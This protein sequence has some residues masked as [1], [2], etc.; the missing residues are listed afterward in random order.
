MPDRTVLVKGPMHKGPQQCKVVS[1]HVRGIPDPQGQVLHLLPG[2]PNL[3]G[4]VVQ[5]VPGNPTWST[6]HLWSC[7]SHQTN[8]AVQMA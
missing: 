4:R 7:A 1:A 2:N 3:R 5:V 6:G 8:S